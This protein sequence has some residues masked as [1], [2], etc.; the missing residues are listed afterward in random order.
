MPVK[1]I[2]YCTGHIK[3]GHKKAAN[4]F[5]DSFFDPRNSL[6]PEK[7]LANLHMFDGVSVCRKA[8]K[9]CGLSILGYH[10]FLDQSIPAIMCLNG[11][12]LLSK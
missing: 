12:H 9:H 7:K 4:L 5:A 1:N 6:D 11:E 8:Q 3:S 10:L 2:V